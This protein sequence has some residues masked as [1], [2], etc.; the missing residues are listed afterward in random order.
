M[1][2][3][4]AG[5]LF[6]FLAVVPLTA[7]EIGEP[8]ATAESPREYYSIP[9]VTLEYDN[10]ELMRALYP[11]Y[12]DNEQKIQKDIRYVE[13]NDT[14]F[15]PMWEIYG[16]D[17]LKN[18]ASFSGVEWTEAHIKILMVRY[19]PVPGLYEPLALPFEG[20]KA[21]D[22]IAAAPGGWERLLNLVVFLSGRN[23]KQVFNPANSRHAL[24]SHPLLDPSAYRFDNMAVALGLAVARQFIPQDTLGLIIQRQ[25]WKDFRPGWEVFRNHVQPAWNITADN[26]LAAILSRES[27]NSPLVTLTRPPRMASA[28]KP[29]RSAVDQI[30]LSA[31]GG[32]L[33]LAVAKGASGF[34]EIT[35]IDTTR[36]AWSSGLRVQDKIKRVNGEPVKNARELMGKIIDKLETEGV[37][38]IILREGREQGLL[39]LP[40]SEP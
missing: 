3:A 14:L 28:V 32:K 30:R 31:G 18:I 26:P 12:Y 33:G 29:S 25:T 21:G 34:L 9:Q 2:T 36:L 20:I 22:Y 17:I 10:V 24:K 35:D 5:L 19:L 15:A 37:Y 39:L 27:E 8:S 16:N 38:M 7:Q 40:P 11:L 6:I 4:L 1:K 13:R 23:L